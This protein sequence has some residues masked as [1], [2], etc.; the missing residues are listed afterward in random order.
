MLG[1]DQLMDVMSVRA[2]TKREYRHV[3]ETVHE[4]ISWLSQ[5]AKDYNRPY[6]DSIR[7]EAL[8]QA[9][10]LQSALKAFDDEGRHYYW[11]LPDI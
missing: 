1:Y 7:N 11:N 10:A 3:L 2:E 9:N 8:Q 4:R 6:G 5:R